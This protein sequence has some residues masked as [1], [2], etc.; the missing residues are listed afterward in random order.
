MSKPLRVQA[1][2]IAAALPALILSAER[3]AAMVA[4]GAHGLRR[5]GPGE[6]FWQYRPA[7]ATDSARLIDWR[8]S[9][10]GETR[11]VRDRE[12]QTAQSLALWVAG[13]AS[14]RWSGAP[15]RPEK[16]DRAE[17]LV[18]ALAMV[19]LRGGERVGLWSGDPPRTGRVQVERLAQALLAGGEDDHPDAR[20]LRPQRRAVLIGDFLG[21][22]APVTR[23]IAQ[24]GAMGVRGLAL[25]VLDP[26]EAVFP[27][28]GAVLFRA[29]AGTLRHDT[30]QA[31]GLR[32]DYLARL[33][34]R[35]ALLTAA[36]AASGWRFGTHETG[37]A[38]AVAL[39]WLYNGLSG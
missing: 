13:G 25:Q 38:P 32:A 30:R 1:D 17:V 16:R 4:P 33:A 12:A 18:L 6:E 22:P 7:S 15:D 37:A 11:F 35:R 29:P 9:A 10:R 34:E 3:L 27:Y 24:A 2:R 8:R 14:M 23:L 28:T 21:D 31:E 39:A 20:A 36:C 5:A 26:D 19:A